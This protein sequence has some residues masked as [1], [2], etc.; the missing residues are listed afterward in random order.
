LDERSRERYARAFVVFL[1]D[2]HVPT[3]A[4]VLIGLGGGAIG[5]SITVAGGV[6][7]RLENRAEALRVLATAPHRSSALRTGRRLHGTQNSAIEKI[8]K[9]LTQFARG[10]GYSIFTSARLPRPSVT[11]SSSRSSTTSNCD[12]AGAGF[13]APRGK[14]KYPDR[15]PG[16]LNAALAA[17]HGD[18]AHF[19]QAVGPPGVRAPTGPTAICLATHLPPAHSDSEPLDFAVGC[20]T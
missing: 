18:R 1:S 5:A 9:A 8:N 4:A 11:T 3:W 2:S 19:N 14:P 13:R 7:E 10:F 12:Q 17:T 16:Y 6:S 20:P 15:G